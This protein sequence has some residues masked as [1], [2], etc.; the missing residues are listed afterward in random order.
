MYDGHGL[1]N[2]LLLQ[3]LRQELELDKDAQAGTNRRT[4]L[5]SLCETRWSSRANTLY[6]FKSPFTAVITALEYL[7]EDVN[8][9]ARLHKKY[10]LHHNTICS[11]H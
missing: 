10:C 3:L 4:T 7:E 6:T 8:G 1:A 9:K 2:R 5:Q 11:D